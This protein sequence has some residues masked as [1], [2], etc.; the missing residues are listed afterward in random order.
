MKPA[1][2]KHL[3]CPACREALEL[4]VEATAG[5]EIVTGALACGPCRTAATSDDT[6]A[7][8]NVNT[9]SAARRAEAPGAMDC[10][11]I[12]APS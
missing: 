8:L 7:A 2:L 5:D 10:G 1:L 11:D 12:S 4:S 6:D 3:V 9:T